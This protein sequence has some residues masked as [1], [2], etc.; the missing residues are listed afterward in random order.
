[1]TQ[2][3][4]KDTPVLVTGHTGFKG[5]WLSLWL[6]RLG[7]RVAGL[8]LAPPTQPSLFEVASLSR[9]V[10][11]FEGD[12]RDRPFVD[13]VFSETAPRVVFHLAAQ[14]LVRPS[15]DDP[16]ATYATNVMGTVNVLDA[17]RRQPG[18]KALV[19][20]TSD[21]CYEN[22][23]WC[24]P[25]RENDP[26]GGRDP[27]SSSKACCELVT[28]AYRQSYFAADRAGTAGPVGVASA[29]AGNVVGGGDWARDRLVPDVLAALTQGRELQLRHPEAVRPWQHVLEPL[30]GYL[31][32]AER[33]CA[34]A[35]TYSEAWN[36]GPDAGGQGTVE[37]VARGLAARWRGDAS[38][39]SAAQTDGRHEAGSLR[40]DSSKARTVLG[41][42]PR[43]DLET[44]L[45]WVVS[46]TRAYLT[47]QDPRGLCLGQIDEY[48]A[49]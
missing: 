21:K 33:L 49:L 11:H 5:S 35:G 45:D 48:A 10:R 18:V 40:L 32:L 7:A 28:A 24:W 34:E 15:Y 3:F 1:M 14:A 36:F 37:Q 16:V 19:V 25:Y 4:W 38:I 26:L 29:R 23:E 42:R 2:T 12:I 47:G 6:S 22:R 8:A 9:M 13:R 17:V 39:G 27:Y 30:S 44:T 43:L 41:W 20:V 46:W 31:S